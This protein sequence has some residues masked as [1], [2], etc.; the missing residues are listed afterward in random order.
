[1]R[2]IAP[3]CT[4]LPVQ[5]PFGSNESFVS[6]SSMLD[7]FEFVS[8]R[9]DVVNCSFGF[10]PSSFQRFPRAFRDA[11]SELTR[12]GGRRGRGLVIVFSAGN[13][14]APT[15]LT[16]NDN[17]NGVRFLGPRDPFT[18]QFTVRRVPPNRRVLTA[19]PMIPG[20]VVVGA[21]SS[22]TRKSGLLELGTAHHRH[23]AFEQT[24]TSSTT[25]SRTSPRI[26]RASVRLPPPIVR[27]TA[28]H[29]D[30]W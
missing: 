1:M 4:F 6:G 24:V 30:R 7:V 14:D 13:D 11:M 18:G 22:T 10:P 23:R 5:I 27:V 16:A 26:N 28:G 15:F 19:Y 9:A 29:R 3:D 17:I 8:D 25:V 20:I 12:T 21:M 2:G